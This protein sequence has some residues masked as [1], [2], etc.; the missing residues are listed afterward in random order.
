MTEHLG[1][2]PR[3]M[4]DP[5]A[6]MLT[7]RW[8]PAIRDGQGKVC[9]TARDYFG[10]PYYDADGEHPPCPVRGASCGTGR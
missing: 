10:G 6:S 3:E 4:T 8:T 9:S 5:D 1:P 2:A 7:R